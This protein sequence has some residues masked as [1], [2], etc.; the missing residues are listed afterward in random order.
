MRVRVR[1]RVEGERGVGV[2]E[3]E[4]GVMR[5]WVRMRM[6]MRVEGWMGE[7]RRTKITCARDLRR[8]GKFLLLL[9]FLI[10]RINR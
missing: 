2:G 9:E 6:R 8:V 3:G 4:G 5:V 7:R 1:V 10:D